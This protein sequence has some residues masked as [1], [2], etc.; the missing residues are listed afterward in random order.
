MGAAREGGGHQ[1]RRRHQAV[2]VLMMLVDAETV[3]ADILGQLQQIEIIVVDAIGLARIEQ[4]RIDIDP[5]AA[6][7]LGEIIGQVGPRHEV[8]PVE[9][10]GRVTPC[11]DGR[12]GKAP[13]C[14]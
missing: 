11:E 10:H 2:G 8:E 9:L 13:Y 6:M 1:L 3:V 7:L 12:H 14:V 4:S 5:Y